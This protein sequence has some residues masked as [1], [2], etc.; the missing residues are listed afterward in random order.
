MRKRNIFYRFF[1]V[2]LSIVLVSFGLVIFFANSSFRSVL[3]T[4]KHTA[5]Q[6]EGKLIARQYAR[7]YFSGKMTTR[8]LTQYFSELDSLLNAQIWLC[9]TNGNIITTSS[10]EKERFMKE[11]L[12]EMNP[13]FSIERTFRSTGTFYDCFGEEMLSTGRPIS[14]SGELVGYIILHSPMS[15]LASTQDDLIHVTLLSLCILIVITLLLMSYFSR[16]IL[17]P[18]ANINH[19]ARQYASGNFDTTIPISKNDEIG[20]LATSLNFMASELSKLE[21]YRKKFISNIS[22]DFRSPLTSIKGYLEAMLD[23]TIPTE[24]YHKYINVVLVE[25]QRLT[26]LTSSLTN[27][28]DLNGYGPLLKITDFDLIP[29]LQSIT[30]TFEGRCNTRGIEI[31]IFGDLTTCMVSADKTKIE[32]VIYNLI[33]NAIKFSNDNSMIKVTLTEYPNEKL[34][35]SIKDSGM[36]IRKSDQSHIWE[37]FYKADNSRGKDKG[38]HGIGLSITKE[39]IRSH[40]QQ[41]NL[42]STEGVGSEFVFSLQKS[43]R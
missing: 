19:A 20:Q 40:N 9:D 12:Y 6:K 1:C 10:D 2:Y 41:I 30:D 33:D 31:K 28:T 11:N 34:S 5:M 24:L 14:V 38:G 18:L 16:K 32:Q 8:R 36:G 35:I 39:I 27:L 21:D 29:V 17:I 3:I 13:E 15:T 42:I 22:H 25:T 7:E 23:G 4:E 43:K 37:R 26:K